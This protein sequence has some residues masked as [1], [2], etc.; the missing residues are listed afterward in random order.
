[1]LTKTR[2]LL[3]IGLLCFIPFFFPT[4]EHNVIPNGTEDMFT[5]GLPQSPWLVASETETKMETKD[6][7]SMSSSMNF[8]NTH[9]VEFLSWSWL[10]PIGSWAL[11]ALRR[12]LLARKA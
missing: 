7:M 10:F 11:F 4:I 1:M 5:L 8:S 6:G 12:R 9:K 2:I 3:F